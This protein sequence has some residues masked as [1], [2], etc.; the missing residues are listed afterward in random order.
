M[1][2]KD[3]ASNII[4]K[5]FW[6]IVILILIIFVNNVVWVWYINQYDFTSESVEQSVEKVDNANINQTG[7]GK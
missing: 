3:L 5:Q 1:K 2:N 6:I 7:I 4:S